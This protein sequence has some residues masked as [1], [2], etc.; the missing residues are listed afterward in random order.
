MFCTFWFGNVPRV[1]TVC[2]FR[3]LNC[4][5]WSGAGIF[6]ISLL[7][8]LLRTTTAY[9]FFSH[10]A[11]WLRTRPFSEPTFRPA[12]S[13]NHRKNTMFR[14]F[15]TFSHICILPPREH[16]GF[17]STVPLAAA[18]DRSDQGALVGLVRLHPGNTAWLQTRV[19]LTCGMNANGRSGDRLI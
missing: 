9:N 1:I 13:S 18:E 14:D 19:A 15:S 10:L 17:S 3:Y 12:G 5:K 2:I 8:N 6:Y 4:Q 11:N 16:D 7:G